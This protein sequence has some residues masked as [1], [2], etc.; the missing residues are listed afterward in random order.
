VFRTGRRVEGLYLQLVY[1]PAGASGGR[2]GYVIGRKVSGRAVD[3]NRIR[4]KLREVVRALRPA[5]ASYDVILRVKRAR[6]RA[7][8]DAAAHEAQRLLAVLTGTG[9]A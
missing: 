2:T 8:Q 6:T 3:R 4:R 1:A 7:E 5:L 9:A